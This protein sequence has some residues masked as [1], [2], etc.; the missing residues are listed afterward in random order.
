MTDIVKYY[1]IYGNEREISLETYDETTGIFTENFRG[2]N[3]FVTID[4]IIYL[5]ELP[6]NV[7]LFEKLVNYFPEL[8]L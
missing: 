3:I 4:L 2:K 1:D 8:L 5:S 6:E 7:L